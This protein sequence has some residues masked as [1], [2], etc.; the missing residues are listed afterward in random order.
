MTLFIVI[1]LIGGCTA[2]IVASAR[3]PNREANEFVTLLD[4]GELQAAYDRLCPALRQERTFDDFTADMTRADEITE[5]TLV[6]ASAPLGDTAL[7]SG[8]VSL[9]DVPRNM[10][11]R[12]D[13]IDDVWYV[14]S[15]D[16]LN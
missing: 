3:E 7:V 10:S 6:A 5:F 14:C 12:M 1:A 11:L 4:D 13:R 8:T 9:S 16:A 15:Y 2:F